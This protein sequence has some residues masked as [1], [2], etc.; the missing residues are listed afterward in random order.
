MADWPAFIEDLPIT[1]DFVY[2]RRHG[3]GGNYSTN[4]SSEQLKKDAKRIKEYLKQG[5]DVYYYFNND[6]FAYAPK[7]AIELRTL[8]DTSLPKSLKEKLEPKKTKTAKKKISAKVSVSKQKAA[9]KKSVA[10]IKAALKKSEVKKKTAVKTSAA[11]KAPKS[12]KILKKT[13]EK[14]VKGRPSVSP[15]KALPK[16][17]KKTVKKSVVK[18]AVKSTSKGTKK[19]AKKKK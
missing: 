3:E 6:A 9:V 5:K 12:K 16:T 11:E 8:I 10:K 4:Y 18:K 1:A 14:S 19:P 15:K 2:I 17:K 7:N 13:A